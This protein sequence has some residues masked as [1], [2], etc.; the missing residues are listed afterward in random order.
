MNE[1]RAKE[2]NLIVRIRDCQLNN[3]SQYRTLQRALRTDIEGFI[4]RKQ[5]KIRKI[6]RIKKIGEEKL[7]ML[8]KAK[9]VK[10]KEILKSEREA[11]RERMYDQWQELFNSTKKES[12]QNEIRIM[13]VLR[14][15][16]KD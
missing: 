16:K 4:L 8:E 1:Q 9:L 11:R 6:K 15:Q 2:A 12:I 10:L 7:K 3:Q 13:R 5:R 14:R